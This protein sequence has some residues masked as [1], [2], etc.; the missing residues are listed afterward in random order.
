MDYNCLL[1][2]L[3]WNFC[4]NKWD[5]KTG[6]LKLGPLW[7]NV[8]IRPTMNWAHSKLGCEADF[9]CH[10]S[11]HVTR[12]VRCHVNVHVIDGRCHVICL[13]GRCHVIC[14]RRWCHVATTSSL[15]MSYASM[16]DGTWQVGFMTKTVMI[17]S[18]QEK[19]HVIW[20]TTNRHGR[21]R[22]LWWKMMIRHRVSNMTLR[23]RRTQI[24][25]K[26]VIKHILW[27][28]L[29][30]LWRKCFVIDVRF[31]SSAPLA[32]WA[33]TV[34]R[35]ECTLGLFIRGRQGKIPPN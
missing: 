32:N 28:I 34:S 18:C 25:H 17:C 15:A 6:G 19:S 29:N 7:I 8:E 31:S 14:Q 33:K 13:C 30:H 27:R 21:I 3:E 16:D 20:L 4:F 1:W 26:F 35:K 24:R 2:F 11:R 5:G 10:V 22:H 12:H 23:L 9:T